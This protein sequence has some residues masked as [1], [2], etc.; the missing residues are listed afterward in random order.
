MILAVEV[1]GGIFLESIDNF[2]F[3]FWENKRLNFIQ[4]KY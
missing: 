2:F 4:R 1:K 3:F